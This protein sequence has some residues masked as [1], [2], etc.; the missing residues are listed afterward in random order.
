MTED[1]LQDFQGAVERWGGWD[2]S[3]FTAFSTGHVSVYGRAEP[4]K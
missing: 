4:S 2:R 1:Q 3:P